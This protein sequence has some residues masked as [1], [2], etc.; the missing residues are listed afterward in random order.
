LYTGG[1]G[2]FTSG[3]AFF[4]DLARNIADGK[5][6][7]FEGDPET[8][9]VPLYSIL[10]AAVTAG[11]EAFLPVVLVQSLIGAGTVWCAALLASELFGAVEAVIA[12]A[13]TAVYPYYVVHDT[14]LQE[15]SLYT[16]LTLTSV[17]LLLRA[18]K[19]G[20][21]VW[22]VSAG[23]AL[24]ADVMTRV[25]IAPMAVLAPLWLG[26]T[27]RR[28]ALACAAVLALIVTPW[29]TRQ[30]RLTG[31]ATL[32]TEIGVQVWN[33]NNALTFSHYPEE[34]SDLSKDAAF[35]A[36]TPQERAERYALAGHEAATD[37]WFL[38][39]GLAY[40]RE[41][42]WLTI[43]RGIRKIVAA[44][45]WLPS[46]RHG[47]WGN[48]AHALSYGPMMALGLWG[49]WLRRSNWRE[50]AIIYAAFVC[51]GAVTAVWFG[52]TSHRAYL[53][54][55]W[56]VFAAGTLENWRGR[57]VSGRVAR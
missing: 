23:A 45:G 9:R 50:D 55:Y 28:S 26:V 49:M 53:D 43:T 10:L 5:G 4:F 15:T 52:H 44:F 6:I 47:D 17:L 12:A 16:L 48:L 24:G 25:T 19:T 32:S 38:R 14:A 40:I 33:G 39:K 13:I 42:P 27:W 8:F 7:G 1:E 41:H 21:V 37:R 54:V 20:S 57:Y 56:I 31:I 3:Y 18:R 35:D 34:S 36:L 46:P 11:R 22:A 2:Y 51:F 30:Y 29:L